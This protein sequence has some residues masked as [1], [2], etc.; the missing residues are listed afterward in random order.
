MRTR[1][2][3]SGVLSLAIATALGLSSPQIWALDD[4]ASQALT[5]IEKNKQKFSLSGSDVNELEVLSVIPAGD[6]G[7]SHVYLQQKY[8]GIDV[9]YG[10]FTVNLTSDGNVLNPAHRFIPQIAAA[11]GNQNA[12][13]TA[14]S[15]ANAAAQ[16]V[17]LNAKQPFTVT[18]SLGG[19]SQRVTL[20]S[21][22]VAAG[23][24]EARLA[25]YPTAKGSVRL[26]W[27]IDIEAADGQDHWQVYVDAETGAALG[28]DNLVVHDSIEATG[29]A[30]ARPANSGLSSISSV[31]PLPEFPPT[32]GASYAVYPIPFE[33]PTDGPQTLVFNAADPAA[34]QLG[35]HDDGVT[36]FTIT[37]GNN[38]QAYT[39]V[40]ANNLPDPGSSPSGG[41]A[42]E[43]HAFHNQAAPPQDSRPAAVT[44][45][46]YWN[47][48]VNDVT[49]NHGFD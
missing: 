32:D 40:D 12:K 23:P 10:I 21:G 20:S 49:Y 4:P 13:K 33:S 9:A 29:A 25:W 14:V 2:I 3:V 30:I 26:S 44:N 42:L 47:N 27:M 5:Y 34:S 22:G 48:V 19:A 38:V 15:A 17:G 18:R 36:Q 7:I 6:N 39:D 8:R 35:W 28:Q 24:V 45:L 41:V 16:H 46:F 1:A 11:A 31:A 37:Q 43:F